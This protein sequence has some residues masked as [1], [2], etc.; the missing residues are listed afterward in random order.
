MGDL[1]LIRELLPQPA[2]P[3]DGSKRQAS[4]QLAH[5]MDRETRSGTSSRPYTLACRLL[6][7]VRVRYRSSG[8]VIATVVAAVAAALFVSTP[9]NNSPGFLAKAQAALTPPDGSVLHMKWETTSTP[10]ARGCTVTRTNEI[11]IDQTPSH[12]YRGYIQDYPPPPD[13]SRG[14][15]SE[16]GG[17]FDPLDTFRFKPPNT[18][19]REALSFSYGDPTKAV[20][21]ALERGFAHDEGETQLDGRAV[22]RIRIGGPGG[23]PSYLY[24]DPTTFSPV[25]IRGAGYYAAPRTKPTKEADIV[26]RFLIYEHLPST[27]ANLALTNIRTQHPDAT[28]LPRAARVYTNIPG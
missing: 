12:R 3:S 26:M 14:T 10:T 27:A 25:E 22:R 15:T 6:R 20:R 2:P 8:L 28:D 24:V 16:I 5:A 11:W 4:V 18:L 23:Q 17:T 13:C 9:W 19:I 21:E 1:D 7:L